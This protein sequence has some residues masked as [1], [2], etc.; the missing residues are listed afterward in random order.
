MNEKEQK[1]LDA[2]IEG[3]VEIYGD[4]FN[5]EILRGIKSTLAQ[6]LASLD[7]NSTDKKEVEDM[8]AFVCWAKDRARS[9]VWIAGNLLHDLSGIASRETCFSPRTA[10]YSDLVC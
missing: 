9:N 7:L 10:G 4:Q 3:A 2:C 8:V 5:D 1:I 6:A